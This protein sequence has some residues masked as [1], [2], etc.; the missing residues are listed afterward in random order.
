MP[1]TRMPIR[2][3][4]H[5]PCRCKRPLGRLRNCAK[6]WPRGPGNGGREPVKAAPRALPAENAPAFAADL[7]G[8][9]FAGYGALSLH[10]H[11]PQKPLTDVGA[12]KV[13]PL[14]VGAILREHPGRGEL[15]GCLRAGLAG[16]SPRQGAG[17]LRAKARST[18]NHSGSIAR[19]TWWRTRCGEFSRRVN[20]CR[21]APPATCRRQTLHE[22][23]PLPKWR[24]RIPKKIKTPPLE[25]R[26]F[27]ASSPGWT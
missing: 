15:R 22:S 21:W 11:L 9:L 2:A 26:G 14:G 27:F 24:L 4:R 20:R 19:Q 18:P 3:R 16:H 25:R 10:S 8:L 13:N 1:S 6:K 12:S 23:A 17:G 5:R 7:P